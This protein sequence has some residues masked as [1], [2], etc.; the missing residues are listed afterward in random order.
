MV[1]RQ[2]LSSLGCQIAV[3]ILLCVIGLGAWTG[4]QAIQA[5][6]NLHSTLFVI[7][8][9]DHF[10][11]ERGRWPDSWTELEEL[12]FGPE[13]TRSGAQGSNLIRVGGAMTVDWPRQSRELQNRVAID[14]AASEAD[15]V[16]QDVVEFRPIHA[17]GSTFPYWKY[18]FIEELQDS[19][20][21]SLSRSGE[22]TQPPLQHEP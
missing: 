17:V 13:S 8:L 10:V 18:G 15:I 2:K 12:S 9:V 16:A 3:G 5:E 4:Y 19:L 20:R 21:A 11:Q 14:F 1:N 22:S 6:Q 7:R